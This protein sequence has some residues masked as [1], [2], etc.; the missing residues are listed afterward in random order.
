MRTTYIIFIFALVAQCFSQT[1]FVSDNRNSLKLTYGLF[2]PIRKQFR[3][4]IENSNNTLDNP[5]PY[6]SFGIEHPRGYGRKN[7][8]PEFGANYFLNQIRINPDGTKTNWF[9]GSLYGVFKFDLFPK[10]KYFDLYVGY[11]GLIG[12]QMLTAKKTSTETFFNF[13]ASIIPHLEFRA[14]P[15][16][17]ISIGVSA[18]FLYDGTL[19]KWLT[20]DSKT[21]PINYTKF[22]GTMVKFFVG[23]CYGK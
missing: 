22:T 15:I 20:F 7:N 11:G 8:F 2:Y 3:N 16:K 21:Y 1:T 13:N 18:N 10:N 9:A 6:I 19:S 23:W 17:R 5:M 12:A 14:Q 4:P